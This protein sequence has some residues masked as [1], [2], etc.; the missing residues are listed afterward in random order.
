M[1]PREEVHSD[2]YD[3][4]ESIRAYPQLPAT[5]D[6]SMPSSVTGK[7][8]DRIFIGETYFFDSLGENGMTGTVTS[9]TVVESEKTMYVGVTTEDGKGCI[10]TKPM[11]DDE[12]SDYRAHPDTFFGEVRP[13]SKGVKEPYDLFKFLWS[14]Y[15]HSTKEK[16]LEFMK[17]APDLEELQKLDQPELVLEYCDRVAST[18]LQQNPLPNQPSRDLS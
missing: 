6:G 16:L 13:I 1:L 2:A 5:F 10:L 11:A 12:L 18:F 4:M 14:S 15:R 7:A 9:A 17:E 3:I 8:Y